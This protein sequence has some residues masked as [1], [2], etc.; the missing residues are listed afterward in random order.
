MVLQL[1][2][3]LVTALIGGI[4][5]GGVLFFVFFAAGW[6]YATFFMKAKDAPE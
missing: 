3:D 1:D 4:I 6:V 5:C 2:S